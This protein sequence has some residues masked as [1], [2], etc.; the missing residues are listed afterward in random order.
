VF[1]VAPRHDGTWGAIVS[2][3]LYKAQKAAGAV[4]RRELANELDRLGHRLDRQEDGFRVS[5]I[6]H[7]VERAFSKRRQ[8]IEAAARTYGYRTAK[9]MELAALRT[10]RPERGAKLDELFKNWQAE[11]RALGF[12]LGRDPQQWRGLTSPSSGRSD[13]AWAH[14]RPNAH[15]FGRPASTSVPATASEQTAAQVGKQLGEALRALEQ[16]SSMAGLRL[17]LRDSDREHAK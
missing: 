14:D 8:A 9:G 6:P 7:E 5:G 17:K 4:Y 11:A 10:R 13:P 2:R 12:E 15:T 16:P 3:E 1:N